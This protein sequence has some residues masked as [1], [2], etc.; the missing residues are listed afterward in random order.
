[1]HWHNYLRTTYVSWA[2]ENLSKQTL[3]VETCMVRKRVY[4]DYNTNA[5]TMQHKQHFFQQ[6]KKGKE[7][8]FSKKRLTSKWWAVSKHWTLQSLSSV[9][10]AW[11]RRYSRYL[12]LSILYM[13]CNKI[14]DLLVIF[15]ITSMYSYTN[16][17]FY[18]VYLS[19]TC[20][21]ESGEAGCRDWF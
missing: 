12:Y 21:E 4:V 13:T 17:K 3:S 1:M 5:P 2:L 10:N 15:C 20:W 8:T 6:R 7:Q 18:S 16:N 14:F 19:N 11:S 9:A